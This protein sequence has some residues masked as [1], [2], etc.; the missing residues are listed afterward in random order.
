MSD[1]YCIDKKICA[2]SGKAISYQ[3]FL[4]E[5]IISAAEHPKTVGYFNT[6]S[7]DQTPKNILNIDIRKLTKSAK[8]RSFKLVLKSAGRCGAVAVQNEKRRDGGGAHAKTAGRWR[9]GAG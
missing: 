9:D 6:N 2:F 5:R 7:V 3:V 1:I 8:I 4:G